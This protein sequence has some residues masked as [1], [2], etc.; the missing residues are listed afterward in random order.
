[1]DMKH[2]ALLIASLSLLLATSLPA[3]ATLVADDAK[4][5]VDNAKCFVLLWTSPADH[6]AECGG[7]FEMDKGTQTILSPV[8][9]NV[10]ASADFSLF[11]SLWNTGDFGRVEVAI[12]S[13]CNIGMLIP[14]F[15]DLPAFDLPIGQRIEVAGC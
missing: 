8:E 3:S 7:P 10:F 5:P 14:Q 4:P 1:M 9:C 13:C 15:D 12:P 2:V 11:P 6:A